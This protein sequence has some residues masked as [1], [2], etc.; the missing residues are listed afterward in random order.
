MHGDGLTKNSEGIKVK[1]FQNE[2]SESIL[3]HF[4]LI[5]QLQFL[6]FLEKWGGGII[7][8]L[9][10]PQRLATGL[11]ACK[12]L[13]PYCVHFF[14]GERAAMSHYQG[15]PTYFCLLLWIISDIQEIRPPI[16][17]FICDVLHSASCVYKQ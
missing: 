6:S 1:N 17:S 12:Q 11:M 7:L 14:S 9:P 2:G 4:Y 10:L 5:L 3:R 8:L 13:K 15:K 16:L